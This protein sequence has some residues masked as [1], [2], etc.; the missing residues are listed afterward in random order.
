[1]KTLLIFAAADLFCGCIMG[2]YLG[3]LAIK[4]NR[5]VAKLES[6]RSRDALV[7]PREHTWNVG[8][9]ILLGILFWPGILLVAFVRGS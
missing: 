2:C 9:V 1:M 3:A 4:Y 5:F 8:M 7:P 6:R